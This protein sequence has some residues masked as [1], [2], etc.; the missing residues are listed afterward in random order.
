MTE[1]G[2]NREIRTSW[3]LMVFDGIFLASPALSECSPLLFFPSS[4][5][6]H[7]LL[8]LTAYSLLQPS[9]KGALRRLKVILDFPSTTTTPNTHTF[10]ASGRRFF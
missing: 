9:N 10:R 1:K 4:L 2:E 3:A 7:P 5:A 6:I 8:P